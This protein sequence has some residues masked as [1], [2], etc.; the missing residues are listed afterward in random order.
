M[1]AN[2]PRSGER[3]SAYLGWDPLATT[4]Q[5][6]IQAWQQQRLASNPVVPATHLWLPTPALKPS[7]ALWVGVGAHQWLVRFWL[8]KVWLGRQS[9]GEGGT[10]AGG[11][12]LYREAGV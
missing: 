5:P 11:K 12:L 7:L 3:E 9:K 1:D 8:N 2:A 10:K 6:P 4:T